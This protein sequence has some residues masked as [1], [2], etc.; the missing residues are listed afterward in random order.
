MPKEY[1]RQLWQ[2]GIKVAEVCCADEKQADR[3]AG[4]YLAVYAQHGTETR[5]VSKTV[6]RK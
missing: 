4:H 3:E 2:D 6:N 5:L 1:I